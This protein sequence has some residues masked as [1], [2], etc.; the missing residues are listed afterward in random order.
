MDYTHTMM[1]GLL[2]AGPALAIFFLLRAKRRAWIPPLAWWLFLALG[3][4]VFFYGLSHSTVPSFSR[5]IT[6]VGKAYDHVDREIHNGSHHDTVHGFRFVPN[7]GN[8]IDLETQII[9]PYW[10][11]PAIFDGQS[12]CV[13]YLD[14]DQRAFKNE[15][16][17]VEILSGKYAGFHDSFDARPVGKW[18]G[19]PIGAALAAFG[20]AGLK[21]MKDDA[22]SAASADAV[23]LSRRERLR[24]RGG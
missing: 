12:F 8:P 6:A 13:V 4:V 20:F 22:E 21:Y 14:D 5:R 19:I 10:D 16:I 2:G 18:L 23:I 11:A 9:F 15:A 7:G 3:I 24:L 1:F 17:D